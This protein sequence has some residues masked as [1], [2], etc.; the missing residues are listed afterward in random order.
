M[1]TDQPILEL[2]GVQKVFE[3]RPVLK[4]INLAVAPGEV[5]AII[6]G[7]GCG[8]STLLRTVIGEYRPDGGHVYMWGEDVCCAPPQ[9]LDQIRRRYGVLFQSGALYSSMTVGENI[10]LP[11]REHTDLDENIIEM[12]VKMKLEL[13]GLRD[14]E[15]L[16]PAQISGGM[17]KRVGLARAIAL[18]PEI[19]FYDEPTSGLDPIATSVIDQL[20]MD[21]RTK[22]GVTSIVVTHDMKSAFHIADR[23]GMLYSGQF[24][25]IGSPQEFERT[26]DQRVRQFVE[27]LADG[28]IPLRVSKTDYLSDLL[29]LEPAIPR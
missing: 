18:D 5:V 26:D 1:A 16:M 11:L 28:P 14:F 25:A 19:L 15:D 9:R 24:I 3:G 22:L 17:A 29:G 7:S 2:K 23:I 27:G 8:K 4:D 20:I 10:A 13:V 6:G 12:V 21:L